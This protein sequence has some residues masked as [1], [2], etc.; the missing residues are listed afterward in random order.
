MSKAR[1]IS[2]RLV[3]TPAQFDNDASVVNSAFIQ[4]AIGNARGHAAYTSAT[5]LTNSD[6]GKFIRVSNASFTVN[7]PLA[8][9]SP[10]GSSIMLW[11]SSSGP[12][13]IQPQ[14]ADSIYR[15]GSPLASISIGVGD[16]ALFYN[17]GNGWV[18]FAGTAQLGSSGSLSF[19]HNLST[20]GYQRLPSGLIIQWGNTTATAN[21]TVAIT[22]PISFT[23]AV[24]FVQASWTADM[25]ITGTDAISSYGRS[26]TG[27]TLRCASN[28]A[29]SQP[30]NWVAIGY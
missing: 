26:V 15:D 4:R 21:G 3:D 17:T 20:N 23:S 6:L 22:F 2:R 14:G 30:L 24:Q 10:N 25:G 19:G 7:L 18:L 29:G 12:I 11:C 1:D 9:D 5:T 16:T 13:T 27:V 28:E 8:A